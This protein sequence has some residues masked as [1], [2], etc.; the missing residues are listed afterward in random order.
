MP[1]T[2]ATPTG[3]SRPS[4]RGRA[5][6]ARRRGVTRSPSPIE[7]RAAAGDLGQA[8]LRQGPAADDLDR[9][10][11]RGRA[12]DRHGDRGARARACARSSGPPARSG[13]P[14]GR[15][16]RAG[17]A[18]RRAARARRPCPRPATRATR[19]ATSAIVGCGRSDAPSGG[20]GAQHPDDL[21]Q[22][23]ERLVGARPDD[24]RGARDLRGRRVGADL[25]RP[26]VQA[27][28]RDAVREH[29]VH[30]A[31]DPRALL[32]AR[33]RDAQVALGLGLARA[34]AQGEHELALGADEHPPADDRRLDARRERD[35]DPE[36]DLVGVD[37]EV[38]GQQ[39][40]REDDD[41]DRD[42]RAAVHGHGEQ[43]DDRRAARGRRDAA[44]HDDQERDA[45]RPA[46]PQPDRER[47]RRRRP[48]RSAPPR[49]ATGSAPFSS[50]APA[51]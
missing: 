49:R 43:R 35:V 33:L 38:G 44:E 32:R 2:A 22:V 48:R 42:H 45:E 24:A 28:Q 21:A 23:L 27:E 31:R 40:D 20:V 10:A 19:S 3:G 9:Q 26:G 50:S 13:R 8:E 1:A 7:A 39:R 25:E 37:R 18:R 46:A 4:P 29:V 36:R 11:V 51:T 17:S 12:V 41:R 34:L 15:S 16:R 6:A 5:R 14:S 30:L 47:T